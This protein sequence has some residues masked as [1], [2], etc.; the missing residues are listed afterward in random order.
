GVINGNGL[1][2]GGGLYNAGTLS[3]IDCLICTNLAK[4]GPLTNTFE[5]SAGPGQ[6]AG[7]FNAQ[8]GSAVLDNCTFAGN[9]AM[10][11]D[12]TTDPLCRGMCIG[13]AAEGGAVFTGAS[14]TVMNCT[15]HGNRAEG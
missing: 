10:G 12:G 5:G 13:G 8:G 2:Q 1:R 9:I 14:M 7:L 11:G 15:F 6:G 4:G 3:L